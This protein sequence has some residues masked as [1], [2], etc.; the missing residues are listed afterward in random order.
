MTNMLLLLFSYFCCCSSCPVSDCGWCV[1]SQLR[2][3]QSDGLIMYSGDVSGVPGH[4]FMA[5]ELVGGRV[6]YSFDLGGGSRVLPDN[7]QRLVN[8]GQWHT[9]YVSRPTVDRHMLKVMSPTRPKRTFL[10]VFPSLPPFTSFSLPLFPPSFPI[11]PA[12][13]EFGKRCSLHLGEGYRQ[14]IFS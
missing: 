4:D 6:Q 13:E 10:G 14:C 5:V 12:A 11:S 9:V 8:D 2:T 1:T 3:V 7:G